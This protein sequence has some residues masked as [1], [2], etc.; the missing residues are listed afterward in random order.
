MT[1]PLDKLHD[2]YQPPPPSWRPQTI[3]WYAVFAI[4]ALLVLWFAGH[5]IRRWI[6]DRYRREALHELA[7]VRPEQLSELLKRTALSLWPSESVA[8]LSGDAW[9]KFLDESAHSN[10]FQ[11]APA[12]LLE[13]IALRPV[14][15]SSEE[16]SALRN[17]A[18][19]WIR[20]HRRPGRQHVQ[21]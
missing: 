4:A 19:T 1:A 15:L 14:S 10:L 12:S 13:E 16:E 18:A 7:Q 9:L 6:A 11:S 2:F 8:S 21:A 17:A 5:L 20:K 3:G